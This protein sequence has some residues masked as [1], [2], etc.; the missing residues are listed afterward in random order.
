MIIAS[1]S[2][3]CNCLTQAAQR[4]AL[5]VMTSLPSLQDQL[6]CQSKLRQGF[7][8]KLVLEF[9]LHKKYVISSIVLPIKPQIIIAACHVGLLM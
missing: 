4:D 3:I 7:H 2:K 6:C 5:L 9:H 1:S 8:S